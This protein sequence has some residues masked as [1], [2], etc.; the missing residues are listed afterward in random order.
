MSGIELLRIIRSMKGLSALPIVVMSSAPPP[1]VL[2]SCREL[3]VRA[4][5]H[6]PVTASDLAKAVPD[7]FQGDP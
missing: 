2:E 6:K 1:D 3:N 4:F 5:F 7:L